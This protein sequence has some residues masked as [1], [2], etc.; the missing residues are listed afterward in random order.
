VG[1]DGSQALLVHREAVDL[2]SQQEGGEEVR[3]ALENSLSSVHFLKLHFSL[4][5]NFFKKEII[6]ILIL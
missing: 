5:R 2:P 6:Q 1:K 3:R 4:L